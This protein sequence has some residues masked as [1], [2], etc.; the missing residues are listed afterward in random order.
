MF[1]KKK[2]FHI[3]TLIDKDMTIRGSTTVTG[4]IRLDGKI[5]GNLTIDGEHG[6]LV[7]GQDSVVKGNIAVA[8]AMIGGKVTGNI[9]SYEY[10]E[11]HGDAVIEGDI[12]YNIL[13]INAGAR[14]RGKLNQLSKIEI[15]K[16]AGV[17]PEKNKGK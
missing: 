8:S 5:Y 12:D 2:K 6:S 15:K 4:G 16:I 9:T 1:F 3:D 10:I 14:I 17:N 7:M 13:E 11:V